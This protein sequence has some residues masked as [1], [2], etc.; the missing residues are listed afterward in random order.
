MGH[1]NGK[2]PLQRKIFYFVILN[3]DREGVRQ[4]GGERAGRRVPIFFSLSLAG[5]GSGWGSRRGREAAGYSGP[6]RLAM[7]RRKTVPSKP[8]RPNGMAIDA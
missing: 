5:G 4:R 1:V 2:F 7:S 6:G 3:A 8:A